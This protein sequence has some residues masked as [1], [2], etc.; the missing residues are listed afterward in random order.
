[1]DTSREIDIKIEVKLR[2]SDNLVVWI[3]F[4]YHWYRWYWLS[5][6]IWNN[7]FC[8]QSIEVSY[9]GVRVTLEE[10]FSSTLRLNV[11]VAIFSLPGHVRL[12]LPRRKRCIGSFQV[13][14]HVS[15]WIQELLVRNCLWRKGDHQ[16]WIPLCEDTRW[17]KEGHR[18]P[19]SRTYSTCPFLE[20]ANK[21]SPCLPV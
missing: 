12:S 3:Q 7:I 17:N 4:T 19:F 15:L 21:T 8:L 13:C 5:I 10:R 14:E 6:K 2:A 16:Y 11:R 18:F 20:K 9:G 1:M